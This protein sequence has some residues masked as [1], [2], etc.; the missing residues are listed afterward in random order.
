VN[1]KI[2]SRFS[3]DLLWEATGRYGIS[4]DKVQLLGDF[5]SF[6]YEFEGAGQSEILRINHSSQR[7][8]SLVMGELDWVNHL[9]QGGASV[10][11]AI[12]SD[13][14][15]LLAIETLIKEI[16]VPPGVPSWIRNTVTSLVQKYGY[17]FPVK[18]SV[19]DREPRH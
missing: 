2:K 19:L 7:S 3:N 9:V 4:A 1:A 5:D 12:S 13:S 8:A 14:G 18:K 11:A 10:S 15:R 16:Y 17:D 6:V